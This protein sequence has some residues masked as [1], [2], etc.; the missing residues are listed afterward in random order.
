[1]AIYLT[2]KI[3]TSLFY[4][5]QYLARS[6]SFV[7]S[8][9]FPYPHPYC[10]S[11]LLMTPLV[12]TLTKAYQLSSTMLILSYKKLPSGSEQTKWPLIYLKLNLSYSIIKVKNRFKWTED[13][14]YW[15]RDWENPRSKPFYTPW[16]NFWQTPFRKWPNLK[17]KGTVSQKL[18]HMLRYINQ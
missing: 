8:M 10:P 14:F 2:L 11:F 9:T 4:K 1:M 7:I 15:K 17:I 18:S 13:C 6:S 3:L 5:E 12:Q 16:E